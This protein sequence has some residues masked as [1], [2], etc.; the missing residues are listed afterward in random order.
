MPRGSKSKY[1]TKQKRMARDI[2]K[3]YEKREVPEKESERRAW[4]TVNKKTGGAKKAGTTAKK[5]GAAPKKKTATRSVASKSTTSARGKGT[6]ASRGGGAAGRK[7][8]TR[9]RSKTPA[10]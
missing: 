8:T 5:A 4:A 1:T 10:W 3:G 9:S 7:T 2:E 6:T